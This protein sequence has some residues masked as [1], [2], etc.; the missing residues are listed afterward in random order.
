MKIWRLAFV[1]S[2][3]S[4]LW[5]G[6]AAQS[7][8]SAPAV[9]ASAADL[10]NGLSRAPA[11]QNVFTTSIQKAIAPNASFSVDVLRRLT[12]EEGGLIHER[13]T[14]IYQ[15]IEGGGTLLTGGT[16]VDPKQ[17]Q[18]TPAMTVGPTR[19]GSAIQVDKAVKLAPATWWSYQPESHTCSPQSMVVS[20]TWSSV[21]TRSR[22]GGAATT[23]SGEIGPQNRAANGRQVCIKAAA[24][25]A[26]QNRSN[27]AKS[28]RSRGAQILPEKF[29]SIGQ[30]DGMMGRSKLSVF[31]VSAK[32]ALP[33]G[34]HIP[35]QQQS[36]KRGDII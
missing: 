22:K 35:S 5:S 15:I 7:T 16:L 8:V 21:L 9:F 13:V 26:R 29:S 19:Q 11:N 36:K 6:V 33:R 12:N 4:A 20:L 1:C 14:E 27:L 31:V 32:R 18:L 25:G 3:M 23:T 17:V 30:I 2:V 34:T 24:L 28:G 10:R